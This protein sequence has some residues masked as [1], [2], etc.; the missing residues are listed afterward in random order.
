ME[1]IG[2]LGSS[3]T[4]KDIVITYHAYDRMKERLGY[5]KKAAN[6]MCR[7]AY[8]QGIRGDVKNGRVKKYISLK[9]EHYNSSEGMRIYGDSVYCFANGTNNEGMEQIVL[10]TVYPLP[11]ELK[12]SARSLQK[13]HRTEQNLEKAN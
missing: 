8:S 11:K 7:K 2:N 10:V 9:E 12:N 4:S 6:R 5:N 3:L 13:K 1:T